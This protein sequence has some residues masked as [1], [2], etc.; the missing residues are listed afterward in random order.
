MYSTQ[1]HKVR[2]PF[3]TIYYHYTNGLK[4]IKLEV[5][6][7]EKAYK[8]G[9]TELDKKFEEAKKHPDFHEPSYLQHNYTDY[10]VS[11][12][13][14]ERLYALFLK[15]YDLF[16]YCLLEILKTDSHKIRKSQRHEAKLSVYFE[17]VENVLKIDIASF[18]HFKNDMFVLKSMRVDNAHKGGKGSL[19]IGVDEMKTK[20]VSYADDILRFLDFFNR[21][22]FE[23][24]HPA[25][26]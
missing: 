10:E 7:I 19:T 5:G 22:M 8:D 15:L 16:E 1:S 23:K 17:H 11:E 26:K 14:G 18:P 12:T 13:R 4:D 2:E 25:T 24:K 21:E 6:I 20:I 3:S 9:I